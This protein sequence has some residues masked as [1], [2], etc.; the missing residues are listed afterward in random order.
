LGTEPDKAGVRG[1]I[2]EFASRGLLLYVV[3]F[4]I[5]VGLFFV[6]ATIPF[7]PGEQAFYTSQSNQI[8][9]EF[10]NASLLTQFWGIFTN[11]F[12]I[13][14]IEMIPGLGVVFF[15]VSLYATARILEVIG[16]TDSTSA[17]LIIIVLLLLFPHSYIELPAYAVA[18]GEG[19][20]LLYAF[21]KWLRGKASGRSVVNWSVEGWQFAINL[22]IVTV[23]LL[24]AA[25]FESVEIQLGAD[26]FWI[27]W[28]P[29]AGLIALTIMLNRRLNR[30]RKEKRTQLSSA[31]I[32]MDDSSHLPA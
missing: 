11:N 6:V 4:L 25:L 1:A 27:T 13:A 5:E 7:F 15:G 12:R 8:N 16:I 14:V 18:T 32:K 2:T 19:L 22:I 20:F 30:I 21:L 26:L 10:A 24:V 17:L 3:L 23:M 29:F 28:L 9:N 31:E